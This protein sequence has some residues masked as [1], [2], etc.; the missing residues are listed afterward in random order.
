MSVT[1]PPENFHL[2]SNPFGPYTIVTLQTKG[3]HPN[4][5]LELLHHQDTSRVVLKS[6]LPST[7][8]ARI[9]QWRSTL[10]SRYIIAVDD[11]P[12]STISDITTYII[13]AR[14]QH[15]KPITIKIVPLSTY[16]LHQT[17]TFPKSISIK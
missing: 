16:I 3:N 11:H 4:L 13:K 5:G 14:V 1:G 12:I 10:R 17:L 9:P 8:A 2:T 15:S 7:P 6:C